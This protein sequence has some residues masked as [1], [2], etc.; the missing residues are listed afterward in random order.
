MTGTGT[1]GATLLVSQTAGATSIVS[2]AGGAT[3]I[4]Y[5]DWWITPGATNVNKCETGL[6]EESYA[7]NSFVLIWKETK[8]RS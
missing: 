6:F 8:R 5:G 2:G 3:L 1:A 7:A 4:V